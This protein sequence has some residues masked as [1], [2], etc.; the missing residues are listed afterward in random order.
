[1]VEPRL[2]ARRFEEKPRPK[3]T[4]PCGRQLPAFSLRIAATLLVPLLAL[5][6][7][8]QNLRFSFVLH[9]PTGLEPRLSGMR[10]SG[11]NLQQ[12]IEPP[13]HVP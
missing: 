6:V 11:F 2:E 8:E 5:A 7:A 9:C 3:W 10:T 12:K 13:E 1:M 4:R